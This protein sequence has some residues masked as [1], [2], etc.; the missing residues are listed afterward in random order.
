M[1]LSASSHDHRATRLEDT[2][3]PSHYTLTI[4]PDLDAASFAGRVEIVVWASVEVTS[5]T[6]HALDLEITTAAVS[7]G[8][9]AIE[10]TVT[11]DPADETATLHLS[12]PLPAG[13]AVIDLSFTGE[14]NDKLVGFY[15]STYSTP[16]GEVQTLACTQ[17]ESTH[18]RR[19][20]P[21]WDEP[22]FKA[23]FTVVL[24]VPDDLLAVSNAA[25]V[26][27]E[28]LGD[29]VVRVRFA[30]TMVM[31]TYLVAFVVGPL[32]VAHTSDVDGVP[33]RVIAPA[34]QSKLTDFAAEVGAFSLRFLAD[35]YGITYPGDKV[36]L[37]AIP[38][39]AFGAMEN[40]GCI[41]FRETALL[42]DPATATQAELQRV[43][44]VVAHELA[45]MW[46]GDLVTMGWW[47]GI[48]L[49]EAFA[50]FMEMLTVDAFR[51][52]W[53]RWVDFSS[54]RSVAFD[55]D[56]LATTR[57]IEYEVVTAEDAEA[58]FDVLTYEKGASV[59]RML[60]QYLGE[61]RFQAGIR[62]Y[63]ERH[64]YSNTETT[65][66]WDA[67]EEAAG[68]PVRQMMDTWIYQAGHPV[69]QITAGENSELDVQR[70]LFRYASTQPTPDPTP[71][72]HLV[73]VVMRVGT[74]AGT[75]TI[76]RLMVSEPATV[77]LDGRVQ[78]AV[79]NHQSNGFYRVA[80]DDGM[81]ER[82]AA[83]APANLS[84]S[85]RYGLIEDEWALLLAG[86][87]SLSR[88][89]TVL[90]AL[91]GDSDLAVW[92]RITAVLASL[93][94]HLP[95]DQQTRLA[96]LTRAVVGPALMACGPTPRP[97]ESDRAGALR[98]TLFESAALTGAD[99]HQIEAATRWFVD[100]DDPATAATVGPDLAD[101]VVQ[102]VA[103][104]DSADHWQI[105]DQRA[106]RALTPQ[107][108]LRH[109]GALADSSDPSLVLRL[110]EMVLTDRIRTQDGLFILRRALANRHAHE[111]VWTFVE[112]HW[113]TICDRFPAA[114]LPRLVEG[115]RPIGDRGLAARVSAFLA[116]H[117]LSQGEMTVDQ[118]IERMWVSVT[119][120]DRLASSSLVDFR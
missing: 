113:S 73:P 100:L 64:A 22:A 59:V 45:H 87:G 1:K 4:A 52:E 82:L 99:H 62:T 26:S 15:R 57:P 40:L 108:R 16:D 18:A 92:R 32:E 20:F 25:E 24:D 96:T 5:I 8:D 101:A 47:N 48:W 91:S 83:A 75:T 95:A 105:L 70:Q 109:T 53:E 31:S 51:P 68:E 2:V 119:L 3:R 11:V 85:E 38:D 98:A 102:V 61:D 33:L 36:D 114:A 104:G 19:A 71:G 77:S 84:A 6:L 60:Q 23:T 37:I 41:T 118:H 9:R 17:F 12:S 13:E 27:R 67:I 78:W 81:L 10:A 74:D 94:R 106:Q 46:F 69:V 43:A 58:M 115:I 42:V 63:L 86:Q 54:A 35:W 28:P 50:T 80:V 66:L 89:L 112:D 90:R 120:R 93:Q 55:T 107:D 117:P 76:H 72:N 79:A 30:P 34:G 88:V 65:D 29:G 14:L 44:D 97:G 56:A 39:F 110:A 49:N 116:N 111:P 103:A 7:A 21:C